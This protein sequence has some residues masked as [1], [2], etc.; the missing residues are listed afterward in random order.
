MMARTDKKRRIRTSINLRRYSGDNFR[1]FVFAAFR[2]L[3][4][5][6]F[7]RMKKAAAQTAAHK[8][9]PMMN[10]PGL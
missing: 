9:P 5:S 8:I 2:A 10:I 7:L 1:R 6:G 3:L 4:R